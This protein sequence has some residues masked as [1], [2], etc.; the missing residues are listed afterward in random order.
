MANDEIIS[1]V[2]NCD[3]RPGFLEDNTDANVMLSG[4][5]STDFFLHG[6]INKKL[7]FRDYNT[8]VI[9]FIDHHEALPNKESISLMLETGVIDVVCYSRHREYYRDQILSKWN[10]YNY[11]QALFLARGKYIAHFDQDS[12]CFRRNDCKII[13]E[14]K[15]Q[16]NDNVFDFISYP[17]KFSPNPDTGDWDY[18]WAST[19][20][21]FCKSATIQYDEIIKCL[22]DSSYLYGKYG[23]K[24][25][26][27]PWLEHVLGIIS[28]NGKVYY[29]PMDLNN[30]AVFSWGNYKKGTLEMLN[31]D[32][33]K[34][35][36]FIRNKGISY[37]NDVRI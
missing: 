7:F 26:L 37:P 10:D 30:Y 14:W 36:E 27:C 19:R 8:E 23:N 33:D 5:R 21:F 6:V 18:W 1:I 3:S 15:K 28:G 34:A 32:S 16:V 35:L 17:S 31:M 29:P 13:D 2:I 4:T 25:R 9:L 11:L 12:A 22:R 24:Y 20:F